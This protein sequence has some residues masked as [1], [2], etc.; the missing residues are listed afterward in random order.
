MPAITVTRMSD[1][2]S[3]KLRGPP[4]GY[5]P[6]SWHRWSAI[7]RPKSQPAKMPPVTSAAPARPCGQPVSCADW[8]KCR[9]RS[10]T[11]Q[12]MVPMKSE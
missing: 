7:I 2:M 3:V 12:V 6:K 11:A 1:R 4:E 5:R 9:P 8:K 10:I